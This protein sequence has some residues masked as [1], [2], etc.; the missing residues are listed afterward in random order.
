MDLEYCKTK[1]VEKA[2]EFD[3][4]CQIDEEQI[5]SAVCSIKRLRMSS[6]FAPRSSER[7]CKVLFSF[8]KTKDQYNF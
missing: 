1:I 5:N 3:L 4:P 6:Y 2:K 8:K 7:L